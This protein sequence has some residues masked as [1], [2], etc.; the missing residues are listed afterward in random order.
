MLNHCRKC[1]LIVT[2]EL[3]KLTD[4]QVPYPHLGS[5]LLLAIIGA[6]QELGLICLLSTLVLN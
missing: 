2:R 5:T 3:K 1:A 6:A 4:S